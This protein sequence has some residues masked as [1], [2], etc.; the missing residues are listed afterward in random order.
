[1]SSELSIILIVASILNVRIT[2]FASFF[3]TRV[4]ENLF[5]IVSSLISASLQS[6]FVVMN[7]AR[8]N[9]KEKLFPAPLHQI[10]ILFL[11]P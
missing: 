11:F 7:L 10:S 3:K 2:R 6:S 5:L 8:V 9:A 1:L 4:F